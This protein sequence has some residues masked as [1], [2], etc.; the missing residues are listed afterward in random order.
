MRERERQTDRQTET[1]RQRERLC[2]EEITVNLSL[3]LSF[4]KTLRR[5]LKPCVYTIAFG[6]NKHHA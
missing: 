3:C 2:T 1:D 6:Q 5:K 4:I